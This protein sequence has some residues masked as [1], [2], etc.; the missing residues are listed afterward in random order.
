MN[1]PTKPAMQL[2]PGE[3]LMEGETGILILGVSYV[4]VRDVVTV[5]TA[6]TDRTYQLNDRV[7]VMPRDQ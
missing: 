5:R 6:Q 2:Q 3:L 1:V 4:A 7:H